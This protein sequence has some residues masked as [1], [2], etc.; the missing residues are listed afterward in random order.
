M[1]RRGEFTLSR[2][3]GK[4]E[5]GW[6]VAEIVSGNT[7]GIVYEVGSSRELISIVRRSHWR[8]DSVTGKILKLVREIRD[9]QVPVK[10]QSAL[11][12]GTVVHIC[13]VP[14][15]GPEREVYGVQVWLGDDLTKG[16]FPRTVEAFSFDVNT[17]LTHHG[18]GVDPNILSIEP[19][20]AKRPS[21]DNIW[22]FY[23]T[24]AKQNDLGKFIRTIQEG[25]AEPGDHFQA[26]ISLTDG[27]GV[28]RNIE[29]SMRYVVTAGGEHQVRGL[30]HDVTD[31]RPH[32]ENYARSM[33]R[34]IAVDGDPSVGRGEIALTS[35]TLT[36]WLRP[37]T[38]VLERWN[39]ENPIMSDRD[40]ETAQNLRQR[41]LSRQSKYLE[42]RAMLSFPAAGHEVDAIIGYEYVGEGQGVM[43]VRPA[44]AWPN[45]DLDPVENS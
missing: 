5:P 9:S 26:D 25:L 13:V 2:K 15:L 40:L 4:H 37:P 16:S 1:F 17:Q 18:P 28:G 43:S 14:V 8:S 38:G 30:L 10:G 44:G 22:T 41:I 3:L 23:D 7:M 45:E 21:Q 24:F 36:E 31:L 34:R 29:V 12:D 20:A 27:L 19:L 33:A 39:H 35:G 32:I 11:P 42:F 6:L